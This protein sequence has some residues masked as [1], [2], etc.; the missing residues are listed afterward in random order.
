[1]P[2]R[3][4]AFVAF[5]TALLVAPAAMAWGP[6]GHRIVAKLAWDQL[7]PTA[8]VAVRALLDTQSRYITLVSIANWPDDLRDYPDQQG[9]WQRTRRM[10]YV[11]FDSSDCIYRP[12]A[13]CSDGECAVAAIDHY[14][15]ILANTAL[16]ASERLQALKFVVHFIGDIHQPLHAGYRKD[17]GGNLYQVVFFG[18][19]T[20]LHRVWDSG[21]LDTREMTW[22]PYAKMLEAEG[23]AVLPPPQPGVDPAAQWAQESCRI[24]RSIYPQG[25]KI[26]AAY[27][28][29]ERPVAERRLREAGARLA[30]V[31]N[32]IFGQPPA[33]P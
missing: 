2:A 6:E 19:K 17:A 18:A 31:L 4:F 26:G 3:R 24:T 10:H 5:I 9:L 8:R 30:G 29:A 23:P 28:A 33:S 20:N 7:T 12:P 21:L 32:H 1:M 13:Q 15:A 11:N 22:K 25:H 27:V 14:E 16:P